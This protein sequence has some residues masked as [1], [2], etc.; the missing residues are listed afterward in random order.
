MDLTATGN[1]GTTNPD[2]TIETIREKLRILER[3]DWWLWSLAL[4]VM[5]LLTAGVVSLS[6]PRLFSDDA[7]LQGSVDQAVRGLIGLVLLFNAYCIYQQVTIKRLR[8]EFSE[9]LDALGYL[10]LKA[11]EFH[12]LATTDPLTGLANRRTGEERLLTEVAR[13][14]RHGEPLTVVALDLDDFKQIN[15]TLGHAAG[16]VVLSEFAATISAT[17]RRTDLAVRLGGDEFLLLLPKCGPDQVP[18]LLGRLRTM[19]APFQGKMI[20]IE[21]SAGWVTYQSGETPEQFLERADRT[22]YEQKRSRKYG[23]LR[24]ASTAP[25][26]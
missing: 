5:L 12:K 22:L 19:R 1:P 11:E 8:R 7:L 20:R 14:E 10:R 21:F 13:S 15:D 3:R 2:V 25:S 4:F 17:I 16:D 26:Q 9:Q 18:I 23:H 6:F 24:I